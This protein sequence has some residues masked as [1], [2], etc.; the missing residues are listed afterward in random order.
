MRPA[1]IATLCIALA[2]SLSASA[3]EA[4]T[5]PTAWD[6]NPLKVGMTIPDADLVTAAGQ[7]FDLS[8]AVAAKRTILVFYRGNW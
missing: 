2:L 6:V 7:A 5:P 3:Q 8:L 1:P 4:A